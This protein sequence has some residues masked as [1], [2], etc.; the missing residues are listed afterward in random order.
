MATKQHNTTTKPNAQKSDAKYL[1]SNEKTTTEGRRKLSSDA[2]IL[3]L[4][5]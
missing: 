3:C 1:Q 5:V 4:S 2:A